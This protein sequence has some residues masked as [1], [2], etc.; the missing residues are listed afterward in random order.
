MEDMA[1]MWPELRSNIA[2]L[3]YNRRDGSL[4]LV[5][6]DQ[7]DSLLISFSID[8]HAHHPSTKFAESSG[9]LAAHSMTSTSH[10]EEGD[11]IQYTASLLPYIA[12]NLINE[13]TEA[14]LFPAQYPTYIIYLA[15]VIFSRKALQVSTHAHAAYEYEYDHYRGS[16][17][18]FPNMKSVFRVSA[19]AKLL[20]KITSPVTSLRSCGTTTLNRALMISKFS[21]R[22]S[23][24]FSNKKTCSHPNVV[25]KQKYK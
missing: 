4:P 10:L 19:K 9:D 18:G 5:L 17:T 13:L 16:V 7:G 20:T 12:P 3:D 1:T 24:K 15:H 25:S 23:L 8:I 21:H 14:F 11:C 2:G 22:S 6:L